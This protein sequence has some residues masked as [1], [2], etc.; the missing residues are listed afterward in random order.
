MSGMVVRLNSRSPEALAVF[1]VQALGFEQG[2]PG[3]CEV[4][5]RLGASRIEIAGCQG[6]AYP[7]FVPGWSP[8]FQHFAITAPDMSAAMARLERTPSWTPISRDGPQRL[9]ANTGCVTAFKFRD[10][11]GHPLELLAFPDEAADTPP[12][13]DHSAISVAD[14]AI[15]VAFYQSLGLVVASRTL[16]R[17]PE[18]DR[19]DNLDAVEV[20]VTALKSPRAG[21]IWSCSAITATIRARLRQPLPTMSPPPDSRG[22]RPSRLIVLQSPSPRGSCPSSA[23]PDRCRFATRTVTSYN[24]RPPN[25]DAR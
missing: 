7:A 18:Q 11:D 6:A 14:T 9:P 3:V 24:S 10:P 13:I 16:N 4:A 22:G 20:E 12:R 1:F 17:G 25:P 2:A 23:P 21:R 5:L 15:A 8:L 19:L